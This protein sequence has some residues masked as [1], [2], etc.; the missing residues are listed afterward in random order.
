M[1]TFN[2]YRLF[3]KRIYTWLFV[4]VIISLT[5][6]SCGLLGHISKPKSHDTTSATFRAVTEQKQKSDY[7]YLEALK[8]KEEKEYDS[9]FELLQHCTRINP[10]SSATFFEIGQYYLTLKNIERGIECFKKAVDYDPDNF[11]YSQALANTYQQK[12]DSDNAIKVLQVMTEH[13]PSKQDPLY[14][15]V[16]LYTQKKDYTSVIQTLDKIE[17]LSGKSEQIS[18]DKFRIYLQMGNNKKAFQEIENLSKE[19]PMELRYQVLLG[20]VY[21]Q[22]NKK[23]EAYNI[24]KHVLGIEPDNVMALYSMASYYNAIGNKQKYEQQLDTVLLNKKVP[25]DTKIEIMRQLVPQYEQQ[26]KDSTKI[27][28]LFQNIINEDPED[29]QMPMLYANYLIS[30]GMEKESLPV[31]EKIIQIDPTIVAARLMLLS[32]AIKKEDYKKVIQLCEP[33]IEAT[34]NSLE[35][36]FYLSIAYNQAGKTDDALNTCKKALQH[37]TPDSKKETISDFYAMIGDIL[38][39]KNQENE[40]YAAYDSALVYNADNISALNNYAYYLSVKNKHL[41][42]AEEMSYKTVKA[43]PNNSTFIDTYAWILFI[44]GNYTEAKIYIDNAIKNGGG[45]SEV[46]NE[47]CGDIYALSGDINGAIRYWKE[48]QKRG[49]KSE[50]LKQK[51]EQRKYLK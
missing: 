16:D 32:S 28:K 2:P 9:A 29:A 38:Y 7:F 25:S 22:N 12:G 49:N 20:D 34:P 24:Y 5:L 37:I 10:Y 44:K 50:K 47:H 45:E 21:L 35:L 26:N 31:L 41:D 14:D 33:G 19:Y 43:E 23:D 51:I 11:W 4:D 42:K 17:N 6:S 39:N 3:A 1:V 13:F 40:A 27:L 36:Y 30:K 18:M 48:S 8:L 15:L 46:I